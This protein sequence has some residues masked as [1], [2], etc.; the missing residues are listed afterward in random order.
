ML[1]DFITGDA[2]TNP[3]PEDYSVQTL[4]KWLVAVGYSR[5][6][7]QTRPQYRITN[8]KS[9]IGNPVDLAVFR[10]EE[11]TD[12]NLLLIAEM[13][14]PHVTDG[15]DQLRKYLRQTGAQLG[16]WFNGTD[17]AYVINVPNAISGMTEAE[18]NPAVAF[19]EFLRRTREALRAE[20]SKF[21]GRGVAGRMGMNVSHLSKIERGIERASDE[22]LSKLSEELGVSEDVMF[23]KAGRLSP[24]LSAMIGLRPE[25]YGALFAAID[26]R[27]KEGRKP[28][29]VLHRLLDKTRHVK[30]GKW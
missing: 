16:I 10:A 24:R 17:L 7:I 3:K 26:Q 9:H 1:H 22:T 23:A 5:D 21:S 18:P 2:I 6:R 15:L 19:G 11:R 27:V 4:A 12:E 29:E 28:E 20:D 13:K 14:K 8:P 25:V 30:D